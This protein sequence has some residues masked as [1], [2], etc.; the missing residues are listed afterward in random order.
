MLDIFKIFVNKAIQKSTRY[1]VASLD[2]LYTETLIK[3]TQC[4]CSQAEMRVLLMI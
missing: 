2:C 4:V 1:R 3:K